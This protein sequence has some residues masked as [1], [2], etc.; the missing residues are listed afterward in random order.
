MSLRIR[1]GIFLVFLVFLIHPLQA[2]AEEIQGGVDWGEEFSFD[3]DEFKKSPFQWGGFF[4]FEAFHT[5]F[6]KG[7]AFYRL[8]F[9]DQDQDD[10]KSS[11]QITLQPDLTWQEGSFK[12]FASASLAGNASGGEWTDEFYLLEGYASWQPA[13]R[14]S[15]S[16]GK[17]LLRWG[18]GYAFSPAAFVSREKNPSDPDLALEG[19]W[20]AGA[21]LVYS[22][23]GNL[24]TLAFTGVILPV[25]GGVNEDFGQEDE[26]N[27]AG[28]IYLLWH[29]TDIDLMAL[30]EGTRT[31]RYGADFSLNILSNLEVHGE[32]SLVKD[33]TRRVIGSDYASTVKTADA[34]NYL[35]GI[36]YL[37]PAETTFIVEYFRNGQGY[38]SDEA[39]TFYGLVEEAS[40]AQ[41]D[42]LADLSGSYQ[43]P[44]FMRDYLY[45]RASQKEPFGWLY[46]TPAFTSIINIDDGSCNVIPEVIYTGVTNLELRVRFNLLIGE[47]GTEYG[48]KPNR[49][50]AE[51]RA[52]YFF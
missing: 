10:S 33:S 40:Q 27:W 38:T 26:L 5:R 49:W 2:G 39:E 22:L 46:L 32:W 50:K 44:N 36:R 42:Q 21:D 35:L 30:S 12:A 11:A 14:F 20:V 15:L 37:T 18:K 13:S 1:T 9:L 16:A 47:E 28:K 48:E 3:A 19:F 6:R 43:K 23:P 52:R 51:G 8:N 17:T 34:Q 41:L 45:I 29:D 7:S 24:K 31:S 4:Q 25:D